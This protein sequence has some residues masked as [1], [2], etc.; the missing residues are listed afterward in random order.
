MFRTPTV[1]ITLFIVGCSGF[2]V[3]LDQNTTKYIEVIK[4]ECG[5]R[6]EYD[7]NQFTKYLLS[8]EYGTDHREYFINIDRYLGLFTT[9]GGNEVITIK[10]LSMTRDY[11]GG[12]IDYYI[13]RTKME[14]F[15]LSEKHALEFTYRG[16]DIPSFSNYTAWLRDDVYR[17]LNLVFNNVRG[18][19][20]FRVRFDL[21]FQHAVKAAFKINTQLGQ[22][23]APVLDWH[24]PFLRR[25]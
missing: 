14:Y 18:R 21:N 12:V 24:C 25:I 19:S 3:H 23:L 8:P 17:A 7:R 1:L 16:D 20:K 15:H 9:M 22:C 4:N 13:L 11:Q 2:N 5:L 10:D 6:I